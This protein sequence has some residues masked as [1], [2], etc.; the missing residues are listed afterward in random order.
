MAGEICPNT[1]D[2]TDCNKKPRCKW[3]ACEGQSL[4]SNPADY[5][6]PGYTFREDYCDCEGTASRYWQIEYMYA[7]ITS[8][9]NCTGLPGGGYCGLGPLEGPYVANLAFPNTIEATYTGPIGSW[10]RADC[11]GGYG[12]GELN[13]GTM[14]DRT[15][16]TYINRGAGWQTADSY[17]PAL[18]TTSRQEWYGFDI[19]ASG[20]GI[21]T[22]GDLWIFILGPDAG[23]AINCGEQQFFV[24]SAVPTDSNFN[25]L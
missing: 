5:C 20:S 11:G 9:V 17:D 14:A 16:A 7:P 13:D 25:P 2:M 8:N 12:P 23:G 15:G 1:G 22:P 18:S 21:A 10:Y 24:T 19:A 4:P 3:G 6:P